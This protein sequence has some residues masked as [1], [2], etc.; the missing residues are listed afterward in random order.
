[1]LAIFPEAATA[2]LFGSGDRTHGRRNHD[3]EASL[4]GCFNR[5]GDNPAYHVVERVILNDVAASA[6][7]NRRTG[8]TRLMSLPPIR[9]AGSTDSA[10]N[11]MEPYASG[12]LMRDDAPTYR[13]ARP[14]FG[15]VGAFWWCH[16]TRLAVRSPAWQIRQSTKVTDGSHKLQEHVTGSL[17][18]KRCR[19]DV[20]KDRPSADIDP[21][22]PTEA[23]RRVS[24][25]VELRV[26]GVH[27][28]CR[29]R[30]CAPHMLSQRLE[31]R[32]NLVL[33]VQSEGRIFD[34]V[35]GNGAAEQL[36]LPLKLSP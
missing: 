16:E 30:V 3:A 31:S 4:E 24:E 35:I 7:A 8:S 32:C 18:W 28:R 15:L 22:F 5:V 13:R 17:R 23:T 9:L 34:N 12:I 21:I 20:T 19:K 1:M 6:R 36:R 10:L 14:S 2:G 27:L 25:V 29:E 33:L 11:R 26:Q